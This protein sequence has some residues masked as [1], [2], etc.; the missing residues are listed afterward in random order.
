MFDANQAFDRV[1]YCRS[2]QDLRNCNV[3]YIVLRLLPTMYISYQSLQLKWKSKISD[4]FSVIN[5]VKQGGI[6]S[7]IWF[8]IYVVGLPHKQQ[9]SGVSFYVAYKFVGSIAYTDNLILLAPTVTAL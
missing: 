2:F 1:K 4:E 5:G 9:N 8:A 7:A 3:S 6:L